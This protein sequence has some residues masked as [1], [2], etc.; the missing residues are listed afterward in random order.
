MTEATKAVTDS[1][2][3]STTLDE[4]ERLRRRLSRRLF[5]ASGA[6]LALVLWTGV[7]ASSPG[8]RSLGAIPDF[9]LPT[10]HGDTLAADSLD[11]RVTVVNFWASWCPPCRSEAP[12]LAAVATETSG[13]EVQFLGVLH[14]DQREPALEFAER[15]GLDFPTVIDDGALAR[16]FG[17]RSIPM[18]FIVAPDGTILAR[19]FGPISE[20]RLRVLIEDARAGASAALPAGGS[21]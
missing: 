7:S 16:E 14:Q 3:D 11:G 10:L 9:E 20:T 18:T 5:I 4:A 12:M 6:I 19:H 8:P 1:A 13:D 21:S 17:V 2:T 15:S